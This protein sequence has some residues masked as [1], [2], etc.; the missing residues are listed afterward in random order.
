M[1]LAVVVVG[2]VLGIA[3]GLFAGWVVWPVAYTGVTPEH[4]SAEGRID[5]A[6][7]TATAYHADGDLALARARLARLG[8]NADIALLNA[9]ITAQ[10]DPDALAALQALAAELGVHATEDPSAE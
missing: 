9:F 2:L 3:L 1:R 10:D 7:M 8:D 4:L 5:Y 6:I